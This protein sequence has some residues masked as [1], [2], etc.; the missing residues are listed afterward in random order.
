MF[1]LLLASAPPA[2][3][4]TSDTLSVLCTLVCITIL[5][6][7]TVCCLVVYFLFLT[8]KKGQ[9][10]Q[11]PD[12]PVVTASF[13]ILSILPV[14]PASYG[15]VFA[16][17]IFIGQQLEFSAVCFVVSVWFFFRL[18]MAVSETATVTAVNSPVKQQGWFA[19]L[20]YS[21]FP[22]VEV[23]APFLLFGGVSGAQ[24]FL[25][26][27]TISLSTLWTKFDYAVNF[28]SKTKKV[29]DLANEI[30][31][32]FHKPENK[33]QVPP[34]ISQCYFFVKIFSSLK[35]NINGNT[36]IIR[37]KAVAEDCKIPEPIIKNTLWSR[38]DG[39]VNCVRN[40]LK[41]DF[42]IRTKLR[43]P[44]VK[45][46]VRRHFGKIIPD[47]F[48]SNTIQICK[49]IVAVNGNIPEPIK[50][51]TLWSCGCR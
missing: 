41:I 13:H 18:Y 40:I 28:V 1:A 21:I 2:N 19:V 16:V 36:F 10:V 17:G 32:I 29:L 26:K 8:Q 4:S 5:L 24:Y 11:T 47:S 43:K 7:V 25:C 3:N 49:K 51:N 20:R 31:Q 14:P 27:G 45:T 44:G 48:I 46:Q 6:L 42:D 22:C 34:L 12:T 37:K 9:T 23:A 30:Y 15:D 39:V 35:K 50:T 33:A 38:F